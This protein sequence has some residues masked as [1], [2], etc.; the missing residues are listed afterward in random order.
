MIDLTIALIGGFA[1]FFSG[2]LFGLF[3]AGLCNAAGQSERPASFDCDEDEEEK[4]D[5]P[6]R[7]KPGKYHEI[8]DL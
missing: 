4:Y 8:S 5:V 3:V 1:I 7:P 2:M 6:I